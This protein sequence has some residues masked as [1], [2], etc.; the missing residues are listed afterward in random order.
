MI[1]MWKHIEWK[2]TSLVDEYTHNIP[3]N[4][5]KTLSNTN[6]QDEPT[7]YIDC[8]FEV[9]V[10]FHLYTVRSMLYQSF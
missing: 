3:R 10:F 5:Y 1:E 8:V 2:I 9:S 4:E 7:D 6:T